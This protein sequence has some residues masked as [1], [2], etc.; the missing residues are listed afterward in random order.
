MNWAR[1]WVQL[2]DNQIQ[3]VGKKHLTPFRCFKA[4]FY[5]QTFDRVKCKTLKTKS[6][7]RVSFNRG[8][9][10]GMTCT[11]Q[12]RHN[13]RGSVSNR[14]PHD[15]RIYSTV[16]SGIDQRK[17]QN[18]A[19]ATFVRGIHRWP[20]NSTHKWTV[21][22]KMFPYWWRHHACWISWR[23]DG[24]LSLL[25]RYRSLIDGI[26]IKHVGDVWCHII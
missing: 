16:N 25:S 18:S 4:V 17:H 12:C 26:I 14:Q 7:N 9:Q 24:K 20:V 1:Q 11:W 6:W 22:R 8:R 23:A 21:T 19:S 15:C 3:Y 10:R 2:Y 5:T 13:G